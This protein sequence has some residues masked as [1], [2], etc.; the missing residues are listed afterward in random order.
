MAAELVNMKVTG[1]LD[2]SHLGRMVR[3]VSRCHGQ[4]EALCLVTGSSSAMIPASYETDH[5]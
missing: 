5:T 4:D 1:G 2:K 3:T